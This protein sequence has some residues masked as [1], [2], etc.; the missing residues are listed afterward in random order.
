MFFA[1]DAILKYTTLCENAIANRQPQSMVENTSNIARIA[2]RVLGVAKQEADNS[3]DYNF[4]SNVNRSADE[5]QRCKLDKQSFFVTT[6]SF[7]H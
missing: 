4:I 7:F 3:E 6:F 5:L 1:E 2:N